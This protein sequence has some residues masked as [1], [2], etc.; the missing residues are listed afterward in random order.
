MPINPIVNDTFTMGFVFVG[1]GLE[2]QVRVRGARGALPG[3][4]AAGRAVVQRSA[5]DE[6]A[7]SARKLSG[8]ANRSPAP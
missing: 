1:N 2:P 4:D 7:P 6:A 3:A 5:D 8:T